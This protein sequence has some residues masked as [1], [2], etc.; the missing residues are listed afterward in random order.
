LC[1]TGEH[2]YMGEV[3]LRHRLHG[4]LHCLFCSVLTRLL[5]SLLHIVTATAIVLLGVTLQSHV[6]RIVV[7][8]DACVI[9]HSLAA[10]C[11]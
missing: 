2:H 1:D 6:T 8:T 7:L 11:V 9:V 3:P 4:T 10:R 5:S